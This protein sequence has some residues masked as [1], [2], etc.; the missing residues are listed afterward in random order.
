MPSFRDTLEGLPSNASQASCPGSNWAA[1]RSLRLKALL[2]RFDED[3]RDELNGRG[4]RHLH[5]HALFG[6]APLSPLP[7]P[8][9]QIVLVHEQLSTHPSRFHHARIEAVSA[10]IRA[11]EPLRVDAAAPAEVEA[12]RARSLDELPLVHRGLD[13]RELPNRSCSPRTVKGVRRP[14]RFGGRPRRYPRPSLVSDDRKTENATSR[15]A[16]TSHRPRL[17]PRRRRQSRTR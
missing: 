11:R 3:L 6:S 2:P 1:R 9:F 7:R 16:I 12:A 14:R 4:V 15:P 5:R 13:S 10:P 8:L 17:E